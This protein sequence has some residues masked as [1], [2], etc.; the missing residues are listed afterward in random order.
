MSDKGSDNKKSWFI[1]IT[2]AVIPVIGTIIVALINKSQTPPLS[3]STPSND[4]STSQLT[5]APTS[6]PSSLSSLSTIP[7]SSSDSPLKL[8]SDFGW[9]PGG[10]GANS[11]QLLSQNTLMIIA[12]ADTDHWQ[13]TD[14]APLV[15][16]RVRGNFDVRVKV[17][18]NPKRN[19]QLAGIGVRSTSDSNTFIR[20]SRHKLGDQHSVGVGANC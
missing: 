19:F 7:F 1:P 17:E 4:F 15:S 6:T 13:G 9:Q 14:T 10:S 12:G 16:Y 8:D 11:S 3:E 5:T 18:I 2:V 20:V